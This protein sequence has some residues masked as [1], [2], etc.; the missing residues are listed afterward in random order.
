MRILRD[1]PIRKDRRRIL[2]I[3]YHFPPAETAGALRWQKLAAP[4]SAAGWSLDVVTL[5]PADVT[6]SG[7]NALESLPS[8]T[9]VFGVPEGQFRTRKVS[10]SLSRRLKALRRAQSRTSGPMD[11]GPPAS[12]RPGSLH[13]TEIGWRPIGESVRRAYGAAFKLNLERGWARQA[14]R[15]AAAILAAGLRHDAIVT[16]GPPHTV[17]LAGLRLRRATGIPFV[18]DMR[19]PWRFLERIPEAIASPVW[20]GISRFLEERCLR[21]ADLVV[22]NTEPAAELLRRTY[23]GKGPFIAV[24]NGS[25]IVRSEVEAPAGPFRVVFA[26]SI[27]LD[28]DPHPLFEASARLISER[29]LTPDDFR[30]LFVGNVTEFDGRPVRELAASAGIADYVTLRDA[31]PREELGGILGQASV[32]V[33]L[34]QDSHLAIPS[35]IYEYAEFPA[36][37]LAI[38]APGG[39]TGRLLTGT[40]ADLVTPGSPDELY[41][42]LARRFTEH[43]AGRRPRPL[44]EDPR[45]QRS[46]QA[47]R[48]LTALEAIAGSDQSP[49]ATSA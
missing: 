15:V 18:V 5:D 1:A 43:S 32:L 40:A 31:V 3:S 26:G 16:C 20:L 17:H 34:P 36:W 14:A 2:L 45:F 12:S 48:L 7:Q 4:L 8:D 41:G 11:A 49:R 38:S 9:R 22:A 46:R 23:P 44:A 30:V 6:R 21:E 35:K 27:Y 13:R 33:S 19:D 29:H 42:A 39:A 25:D 24:R 37:L 47:V 10:R 28:R